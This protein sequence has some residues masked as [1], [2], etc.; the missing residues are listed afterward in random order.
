M[1]CRDCLLLVSFEICRKIQVY[2]EVLFFCCEKKSIGVLLGN[3]FRVGQNMV[4]HV[5]VMVVGE[6]GRMWCN[7]ASMCLFI[8]SFVGIAKIRDSD[9]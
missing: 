1:W 7:S 3:V 4:C 2:A 5:C 8:R 6:G 9:E